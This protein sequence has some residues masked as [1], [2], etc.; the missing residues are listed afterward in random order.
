MAYLNDFKAGL[1]GRLSDK[2]RIVG[3]DGTVTRWDESCAPSPA[4]TIFPQCEE[5]VVEIVKFC[6]QKGIK[7]F[8]QGGGHSWRVRNYR[9]IDVVICLRDMNSV[10]ID[11]DSRKINFG[12]GVVVQEL[13]EAA[14]AKQLEVGSM[15]CGGIGRY[16]GKYGL[17][18]DN[19]LS[20]NFVDAAGTLHQ[21]VSRETDEDLWWA[22]RGAGTS[23]GIITQATVQAYPQSNNGL[24]WTGTLIF[25]DPSKLEAVVEAINELNM[26]ENMCVHLLFACVPPTHSPAIMVVPWYY[27]PEE[28]AERAWKPLL[29]VGPTIR[30]TFMAPANRL[31]DGNDPFGEKGGRK[32]GLGLGLDTLDPKAYRH[33]WDL[34]IQF[35]SENPDAARTVILAERY[36]RAKLLSIDRDS[37]VFAHRGSKYEAI[38]VPWYTDHKLDIRANAFSQTVRNIWIQKCCKPTETFETKSYIA[39]SGLNE[40]LQTL[41]GDQERIDKLMGIKK[42]WDPDNYWGALMDI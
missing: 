40:P 37:T 8:A 39:F 24:S 21:G 14:T 16:M 34:Y 1:E 10:A 5:D 13:I 18:A 3:E 41:F 35:L 17:A 42:K 12:G 28:E 4:V 32:P 31:N 29:D 30:E 22:I 38:C 2:A 33:I 25:A 11:E 9:E 6:R 23:F 15:L 27:G 26:D 7:C 20:C 19:L 36:S